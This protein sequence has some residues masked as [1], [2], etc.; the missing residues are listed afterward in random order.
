MVLGL[1]GHCQPKAAHML[2]VVRNGSV[3]VGATASTTVLGLS[4]RVWLLGSA[5][6]WHSRRHARWWGA[7]LLLG[8]WWCATDQCRWARLLIGSAG[9]HH[10]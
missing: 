3:Q 8:W 6:H 7:C 9:H 10:S 4:A 5:G 2:V 1:S